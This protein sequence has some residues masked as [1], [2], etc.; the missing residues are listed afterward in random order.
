MSKS[1]F[2]LN[3]VDGK[4]GQL[5]ERA[6]FDEAVEQAVAIATEQC[7]TPEKEIREEIEADTNFIPKEGGFAV[8]LLQTEDE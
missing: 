2:I 6:T 3:I 4:P 1:Y 8:Y 7:D 5:W